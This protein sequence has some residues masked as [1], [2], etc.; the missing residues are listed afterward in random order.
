MEAAAAA[1]CAGASANSVRQQIMANQGQMST[2]VYASYARKAGVNPSSFSTCMRSGTSM[3]KVQ[4]DKA[5]GQ[6]MGVRGTPTL[7]LGTQDAS[8]N[9]RPVKLV[10]GYDPPQQVLAEIDNF[11]ASSSAP[12]KQ[13]TR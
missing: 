3:Q 9:V 7:V 12:R 5:L 10:K 1:R 13:Q 2:N 11:I 6:S 4:A 8:G